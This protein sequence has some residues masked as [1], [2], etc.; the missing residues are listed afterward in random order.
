ML[1]PGKVKAQCGVTY[2]AIDWLEERSTETPGKAMKQMDNFA[3][4]RTFSSQRE[5]C[6]RICD[7]GGI[8]EYF[9][10]HKIWAVSLAG[11]NW[12]VMEQS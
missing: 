6:L 1:A 9:R 12:K 11:A 8:N 2:L 10:K 3:R 7:E 4:T 5:K